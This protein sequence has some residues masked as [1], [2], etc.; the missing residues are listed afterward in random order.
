MNR[1]GEERG[2]AE[3]VWGWGEKRHIVLSPAPRCLARKNKVWHRAMFFQGSLE[4]PMAL[5]PGESE[6]A[7]GSWP[8]HHQ[9]KRKRN[10]AMK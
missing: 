9:H 3:D 4:M 7:Y 2:R 10:K 1:D 8:R 5:F 6:N